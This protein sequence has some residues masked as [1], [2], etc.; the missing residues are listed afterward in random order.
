M[1]HETRPMSGKIGLITGASSGIGRA[2]A[3]H[4]AASGATLWLTGRCAEKLRPLAETAPRAEIF[5]ADL[6]APEQVEALADTLARRGGGLDFLIHSAGAISRG[7]VESAAAAELDRQW[8]INLRAPYVITQA[9]LPLLKKS[10]GQIVFI[11]SSAGIH[12]VAGS[13]GYSATKHALKGFADSLRAE[14]NPFGIRVVSL[15]VGRTATPMQES[16]HA[17][18]GRRYRPEKLIQPGD[19]AA[20]IAHVLNLPETVE[21]TALYLRPA[22]P[23]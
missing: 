10:R 14:V 8:N 13:A 12:A 11:N 17:C 6:E 22:Q 23:S 21:V 5:T 7:A 19:V 9:L 3:L 1:S 2:I 16:L 18:E 15:F 4:L 20:L